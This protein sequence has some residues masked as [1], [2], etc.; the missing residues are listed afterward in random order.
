MRYLLPLVLVVPVTY[1]LPAIAQVADRSSAW[2]AG[3]A[4]AFKSDEE[5]GLCGLFN[6]PY[7]RQTQPDQHGDYI[8]GYIA[9]KSARPKTGVCA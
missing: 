9:G 8:A 4:D 6:N 1:T 2:L 3:Y 5:Q 7:D